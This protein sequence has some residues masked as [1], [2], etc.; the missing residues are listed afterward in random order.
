M[1]TFLA[2]LHPLISRGMV[3]L[4]DESFSDGRTEYAGWNVKPSHLCRIYL[5][6]EDFSRV[7]FL[8]EEKDRSGLQREAYRV[9]KGTGHIV[10]DR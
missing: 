10:S 8:P 7:R 3:H 1:E 9:E 5:P 6:E 2:E 4:V